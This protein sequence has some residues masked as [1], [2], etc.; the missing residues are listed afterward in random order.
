ME[1]GLGRMTGIAGI[2]EEA[3]IG[4]AENSDHLPL[5]RSQR[6]ILKPTPGRMVKGK[7]TEHET[8]CDK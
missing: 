1:V 6:S 4:Q 8:D 7:T 2:G 3:E 5:L